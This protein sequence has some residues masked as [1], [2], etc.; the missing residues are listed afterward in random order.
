MR[1]LII[2]PIHEAGI[3][4]LSAAGIEPVFCPAPDAETVMQQIPG[5]AAAITRDAGLDASGFAAGDALRVLSVHG[6]GFDAVDMTAA[7]HNRVLITT[8]PGTNAQSVAEL[9]VGLALAV[10]RRIP[11]ADMAMRAGQSDF[12]QSAR[13]IE[14]AGKTALIIGWGA[15]GRAVGKILHHAFGMNVLVHS[16]RAPETGDFGRVSLRDGLAQADLVSLHT[17]LRDETRNMIDAEALA[18]MRPGAILVNMARAGLVDEA[19]LVAAL[20]SGRLGGAGLDLCSEDA[21]QGPLAAY[22]N[23]VFT[24]HLGGTT[25]DALRRT[26]EAAAANV[27]AA[28]AGRPPETALNAEI[29]QGTV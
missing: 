12:R 1:C 15:I 9:T 22:P 24:P 17:P 18:V 29:W 20:S 5:C 21:P 27:I 28:L 3:T 11:A 19:A 2:Q 14:L 23:V 25:D 7:A 26:A 4:Q 10:A 16:P 8:T 6:A 13:F